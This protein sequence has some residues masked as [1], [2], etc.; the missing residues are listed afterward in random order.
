MITLGKQYFK[1]FCADCKGELLVEGMEIDRSKCK[2][3]IFTYCMQCDKSLT[4]DCELDAF[5]EIE[6]T[7]LGIGGRDE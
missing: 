1:V 7:L 3:T 5:I 2:Y 4:I 6:R